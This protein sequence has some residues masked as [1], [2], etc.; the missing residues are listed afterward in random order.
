MSKFA[1]QWHHGDHSKGPMSLSMS[2][3][4]RTGAGDYRIY[5]G[6][7]DGPKGRFVYLLVAPSGAQ[8]EFDKLAEAKAGVR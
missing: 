2:W 1:F 6:R 7:P 5:Q 4:L 8:Q 3:T